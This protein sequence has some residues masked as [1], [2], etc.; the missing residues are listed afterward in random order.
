[1]LLHNTYNTP[2]LSV[3]AVLIPYYGIFFFLIFN[4]HHWLLKL[5]KKKK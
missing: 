5:V 3:I 2:I 1:M 4:I